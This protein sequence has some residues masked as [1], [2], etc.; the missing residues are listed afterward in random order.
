MTLRFDDVAL[1]LEHVAVPADTAEHLRRAP[2]EL[3]MSDEHVAALNDACIAYM[4]EHGS[5]G[6]VARR[7]ERIVDALNED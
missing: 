2:L 5:K 3:A 4:Q 7:L 1:V 6:D